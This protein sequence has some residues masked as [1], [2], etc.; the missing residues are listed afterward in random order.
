MP[1]VTPKRI[2]SKNEAL[3]RLSRWKAIQEKVTHHVC[4]PRDVDKAL[5]ADLFPSTFDQ[6]AADANESPVLSGNASAEQSAETNQTN[7]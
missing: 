6:L 4:H 1:H 5:D 7:G 3:A 2:I